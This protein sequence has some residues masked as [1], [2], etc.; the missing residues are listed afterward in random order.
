M[1]V[2]GI[3]LY[4]EEPGLH[5]EEAAVVAGQLDVF[6]APLPVAPY[7]KLGRQAHRAGQRGGVIVENPQPQEGVVNRGVQLHA[8][9]QQL[10]APLPVG[11]GAPP[12]A[13]HRV[14]PA[15]QPVGA[16][17]EEISLVQVPALF[18]H[19]FREGDGPVGISHEI[20]LNSGEP[21]LHVEV[22][23][24]APPGQGRQREIAGWVFGG[25][26]HYF[27][28][29]PLR[30]VE[31][32][33]VHPGDAPVVALVGA[34]AQGERPGGSVQVHQGGPEAVVPGRRRGRQAQQ[35]TEKQGVF[36]RFLLTVRPAATP[37]AAPAR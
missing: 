29:L 5:F 7:E 26:A 21:A 27:A 28:E 24:I 33:P 35:E 6:H 2:H 9:F 31:F 12:V 17:H 11:I 30:L 8:F 16:A 19:F 23:R 22:L 34:R 36:H 3:D 10:A 13:L 4:E 20:F 25:K 18:L 15:L 1:L 14:P 37:P 32:Q